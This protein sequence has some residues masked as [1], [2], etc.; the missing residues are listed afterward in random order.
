MSKFQFNPAL[1]AAIADPRIVN[2]AHNLETDMAKWRQVALTVYPTANADY[3][4][5]VC[6]EVVRRGQI[7]CRSSPADPQKVVPFL[8]EVTRRWLLGGLRI[9]AIGAKLPRDISGLGMLIVE[10]NVN[11]N[12]GEPL[13]DKE[14]RAANK[15]GK[16]K[17]Q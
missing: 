9:E 15:M 8:L 10:L 11:P 13:T 2:I 5:T 1:A 12:T 14:L 17:L 16:L 4:R 7:I 3:V 6:E